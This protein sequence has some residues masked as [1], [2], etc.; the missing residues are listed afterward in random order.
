[1]SIYEADQLTSL[2]ELSR[3][4]LIFGF[5]ALA[6]LPFIYFCSY[7]FK[8]PGSGEAFA[9]LSCIICEFGCGLRQVK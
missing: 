3:F 6:V 9:I 2:E 8:K 1:M 5:Y 4:V 7:I